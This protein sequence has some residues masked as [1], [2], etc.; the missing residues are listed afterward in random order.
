MPRYFFNVFDGVNSP[1]LEGAEFPDWTAARV[2][3]R[4]VERLRDKHEDAERV[5]E[6]RAEQ[7]VLDEIA[8]RGAVP[9]ED[10]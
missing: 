6:Q 4:A 1:D 3:T 7:V 2:R 5:H 9:G 10:A 8:A